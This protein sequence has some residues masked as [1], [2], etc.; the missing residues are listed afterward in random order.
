M[1]LE[2]FFL[3]I[4]VILL[5]ISLYTYSINIKE[6]NRINLKKLRLEQIKFI[7]DPEIDEA[8]SKILWEWEWDDYDDYW[9]KYSPKNNPVANV[10]RRVARNYYVALAIMVKT[11]IW[12]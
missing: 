10:T 4:S 1:N 7:N 12:I 5:S 9:K 6:S 3:I 8:L 2:L 11:T